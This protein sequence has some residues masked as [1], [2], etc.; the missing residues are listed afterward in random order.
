[1]E[2]LALS[3][4]YLNLIKFLSKKNLLYL[5]ERERERM[6]NVSRYLTLLKLKNIS[7]RYVGHRHVNQK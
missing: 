4:I 6:R 3:K 1:M 5:I 2:I 7:F